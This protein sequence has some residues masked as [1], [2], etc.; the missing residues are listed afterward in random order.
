MWFNAQDLLDATDG[1]LKIILSYY[2]QAQQALSSPRKE[3]KIRE[4]EKT[5]S[6]RLKQLKDGNWV[7]TDFG[8]D[9]TPRNGIQVCQM[10]E[11]LN[12]REALAVLGT[13]Y[14]IGGIKK[15]INKAGFEK[16]TATTEEEE[17]KYY[18][19]VKEKLEEW[20]IKELGPRVTEEVCKCYHVFALNSFTQIKN[21]M[22]LVTSSNENYPIFLIDHC[23]WQKIYQPRNPDKQYRFRYVGVKPKDWINGLDQLIKAHKIEVDHAPSAEERTDKK[24]GK[25]KEVKRPAV[26]LCSGDRDALNVAGMGHQVIW[27][28]SETAE[29]RK[30][31]FK[32]IMKYTE[33]LYNLPDIDETGVKA[34]IRLGMQ[35]LDIRTIWLPEKLREFHDARGNPRKDLKDFVELYPDNENFNKL[36]KVAVP[37]RF[38]DVGYEKDQLKYYFNNYHAFHFLRCNG[39]YIIEDK[40]SKD[41][42]SLIRIV[43]NRV[44]EIKQK[45]VKDFFAKFLDDRYMPIP[46]RNMVLKSAQLSDMSLANLPEAKPDFTDFDRN[47]QYFFFENKTWCVTAEKIQEYRPEEV[48]RYVWASEIIPHKVKLVETPFRIEFR[49][50]R[51][52]YDITILDYSS[53]FMRFLINASRIK[54][55]DELE[56]RLVKLDVE[57]QMKYL[58]KNRW[59]L[60]G[61]LLS[62]E[63][64][65]EH[66]QHL[67][68]K[69]FSIGYLLSR[70]KDPARAWCVFAM[71]NKIDEDGRSNGRSG[72]SMC[73]QTLRKFMNSVTL[74]GRDRQMTE[75]KHIYDRVTVH[76]DF[77]LIDDADQYFD[78]GFFFDA[79]TGD[80]IVNPKN[81]K[82]YE[83]PFDQAPKFC[84]TS[85]FTLRRID[86]STEGRILYTVFSDYYHYKMEHSEYHETRT[87]YDDFGKSLFKEDYTEEEWNAD[88]NFFAQCVRFFK[89]VPSPKKINPP[90]DMVTKRNLRT[91]ITEEFFQWASV[92][93]SPESDKVNALI[94]KEEAFDDFKVKTNSYKWTIN[95]FTASLRSYCRYESDRILALDP[96]QFRNQQGR[97]IRK[98]NG[99]ATEMIYIQTRPL[100]KDELAQHKAPDQELTPK[101][102]EDL[103]F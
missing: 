97:I 42:F 19:D 9:Q 23:E 56:E 29:L 24:T 6:S 31:D 84:V 74:P 17:G 46:L 100:T 87:V 41:D 99:K 27:L 50:D 102:G 69:I 7:V 25:I 61:D 38:W 90:M 79:V 8:G 53:P 92:Y 81:N 22:A 10:E 1:G 11:N 43:K 34:A 96:D 37:M 71:D 60:D 55:K 86:P 85:N 28:N 54:W 77:I 51:N 80:L 82:S 32:E 73:Y 76:T 59:R 63:E 89:Q 47:S 66:K 21:R 36:M 103:P 52:E 67:I 78:F 4:N 68:N 58:E 15:E 20:E 12:F 2:P 14:G 3:F 48:D 39:F 62:Q 93:F 40:N 16:R 30:E 72:K 75:N 45:H 70:Y 26:I 13:R 33:V 101:P 44:Y 98:E 91:A 35:Y 95:K 64:I 83:I 18:F 57:A 65:W 94:P 88:L 49:E 5:P